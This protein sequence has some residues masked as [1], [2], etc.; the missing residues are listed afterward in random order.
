MSTAPEPTPL[1]SFPTLTNVPSFSVTADMPALVPIPMAAA[2]ALSALVDHANAIR[3]PEMAAGAHAVQPVPS[4]IDD[5]DYEPALEDFFDPQPTTTSKGKGKAVAPPASPSVAGPSNDAAVHPFLKRIDYVPGQ[6]P[7]KYGV[8]EHRAGRRDLDALAIGT[9]ALSDDVKRVQKELAQGMEVVSAKLTGFA[10]NNAEVLQAIRTSPAAT[11]V[12]DTSTLA[13][14]VT[15]SNKHSANVTAIGAAMN[16]LVNRVHSLENTSARV[17]ALEATAQSQAGTMQVLLAR[18]SAQEAATGK[19]TLEH[20][21]DPA[22]K[23]QHV[24]PPTSF[25]YQYPLCPP[26]SSIRLACDGPPG[27]PSRCCTGTGGL[28]PMAWKGNFGAA[29]RNL[30]LAVLGTNTMRGVRYTT[31]RGSDD[32]TALLTFDADA[33]ATWFINAWNDNTRVG[34][35]VCYASSLNV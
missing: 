1:T 32:H 17:T 4:F 26:C 9:A 27:P 5:D 28:G 21:D 35:E 8:N 22:A 12:L 24:M 23:H 7:T 30:V 18:V 13:A 29:P 14:L 10:I 15:A 19:R 20:D 3:P 16:D 11:S 25:A 2:T 34:Y 31:R 6:K 33:V